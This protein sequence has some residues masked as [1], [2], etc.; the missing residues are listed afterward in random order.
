M[1][2]SWEDEDGHYG[3]QLWW[4]VKVALRAVVRA[5][6]LLDAQECGHTIR[7]LL[8]PQGRG[9]RGGRDGLWEEGEA[10]AAP[11]RY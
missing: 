2:Q 10:E 7:H 4:A 5:L 11:C 6:S 1:P 3:K 8:H 9:G